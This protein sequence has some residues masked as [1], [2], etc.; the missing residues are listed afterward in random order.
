MFLLQQFAARCV[1]ANRVSSESKGEGVTVSA[2]AFR[3]RM[4]GLSRTLY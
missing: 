4:N 3:S 1:E 2:S